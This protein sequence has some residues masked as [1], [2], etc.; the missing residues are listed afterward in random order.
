M[1]FNK[2]YKKHYQPPKLDNILVEIEEGIAAASA[3]V[4]VKEETGTILEEWD[5]GTDREKD[6]NW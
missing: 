6:V 1:N 4:V 5:T 2:S 3:I